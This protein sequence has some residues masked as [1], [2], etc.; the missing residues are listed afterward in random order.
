MMGA[1]LAVKAIVD[2]LL[3]VKSDEALSV[4]RMDRWLCIHEVCRRGSGAS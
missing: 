3:R 4:S 1:Y 2:V